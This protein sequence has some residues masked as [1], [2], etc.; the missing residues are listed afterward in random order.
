MQSRSV[1]DLVLHRPP[2]CLLDA[3][4]SVSEGRIV[5]SL[6]LR[7]DS[8]FVEASRVRSVVALE[9]MAQA[10]AA[11]TGAL[12]LESGLAP[13]RG[14]VVTSRRMDFFVPYFSVGEQLEVEA[15][16]RWS[17]GKTSNFD[18]VVR[19][20]GQVTVEG[21]LTTHQPSPGP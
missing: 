6:T 9:W 17:D 2:M 11:H 15:C 7:E 1:Q 13:A 3:V 10:V 4:H 12:R 8:A 16:L 20:D 14:Y 19:R 18:C 21:T 5:C